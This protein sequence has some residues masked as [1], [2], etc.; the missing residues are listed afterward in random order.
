MTA[1]RV[2]IKWDNGPA[3]AAAAEG[4]KK[5]LEKASEIVLAMANAHA[6]L[7]TGNLIGT[8]RV[9]WDGKEATVY[10]DT[11]YAARLHQNPKWHFQH[12]RQGKWLRTACLKSKPSVLQYFKDA[13]AVR[14]RS[15]RTKAIQLA[16]GL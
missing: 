3:L 10:Y 16:R 7:D 11:V 8:G 2:R 1:K 14:F 15:P 9:D 13:L 5:G 4:S 6:P 12:G